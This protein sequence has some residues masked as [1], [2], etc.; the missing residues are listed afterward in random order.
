MRRR[1][2]ACGDLRFVRRLQSVVVG[3]ST[4]S[5]QPPVLHL[6]PGHDRPPPG[7]GIGLGESILSEDVRD[8]LG[9][10]VKK[11]ALA[12]EQN[13]RDPLVLD[14]E[15]R[16]DLLVGGL[17][18]EAKGVLHEPDSCGVSLALLP[19]KLLWVH[20]LLLLRECILVVLG[21]GK[22]VYEGV[23]VVVV[24]GKCSLPVRPPLLPRS[25]PCLFPLLARN[26]QERLSETADL[27]FGA[28]RH[29]GVRNQLERRP[30]QRRR[31]VQVA[32]NSFSE[33]ALEI[34]GVEMGGGMVADK[35]I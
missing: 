11:E 30:T 21:R 18:K 3:D 13:V 2:Q 1:T 35:R 10:L 8:A 33:D 19:R 20:P 26:G 32:T 7:R 23:V 24:V 15:G 6:A 14:E 27:S 22:V 16:D 28:V 31:K 5:N 29:D 34:V 9:H 4:G 17:N 12:H 25:R